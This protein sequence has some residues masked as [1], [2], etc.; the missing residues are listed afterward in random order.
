MR[1]KLPVLGLIFIAIP[2][3]GTTGK[4]VGIVTDMET[5]TPLAHV[6]IKVRF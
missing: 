2:L 4:I 6:N 5:G 3:C 1:T